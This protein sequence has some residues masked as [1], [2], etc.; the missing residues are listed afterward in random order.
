MTFPERIERLVRQWPDWSRAER[1]RMDEIVREVLTHCADGQGNP[2]VR[3]WCD[4]VLWKDSEEGPF[5]TLDHADEFARAEVGVPWKIV[6]SLEG[7]RVMVLRD[8]D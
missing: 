8:C 7:F 4:R 5:Q 3:A 6:P 1:R 2:F